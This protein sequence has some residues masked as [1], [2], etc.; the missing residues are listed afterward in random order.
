MTIITEERRLAIL[1]ALLAASVFMTYYFNTVVMLGTVFS[2]F[3]YIPIILTAL[4]WKKRSIPVALFLGGLVIA[5]SFLYN[6]PDI[7]TLNDYARV[8]TFVVIAFVV[9]SLSE[10]L[11]GR[12]REVVEQRDLVQR[13]LDV[14]GVL[15]VVINADHT[16]RL[17]NRHGCE[18]LGYRE[19]ELIGK[20][21][22]E[23]VVPEASRKARQEIFDAAIAGGASL[24]GRRENPVVTRSGEELILAWQDT[25][26]A[27]DGDRPAAMIGSGVDITDRIRAEEALR[28]AHGEANLYLDIMAHD[29]NNANAVALGYSDLLA[30]ELE[31][32]RQ[33]EMVRKLRGSIDRSID[34]IQNV[35]TIRRLRSA[36]PSTR[37]V[38]LDAVIRAEI[39]HHPDARIVYEGEPVRVTADDLLPEVFTNLIGNSIKFGEPGVEVRVRVEEGDGVVEV[40]VEDTGPGVPDAVKAGLFTRFRRGTSARSGKGLG[41]YITRMLVERYG[42]RIRVEDRIPGYPER[43]AAFRFT[44][45]RCGR[46][47]EPRPATARS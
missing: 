6:R 10:Q 25:V 41:L 5:S 38:D 39:A 14:A 16:I 19:E 1:I 9:A 42:G 46:P 32:E 15:F 2:H 18:L 7:L 28:E 47:W 13:Y 30:G 36:E 21:W 37:P 40:T 3:F 23:I 31:G 34:I 8:M 22:F 33:R 17:V 4:W 45:P 20:N 26:L 35:S 12:E 43:G 29:I 27:G 44:L 11:K 24:S